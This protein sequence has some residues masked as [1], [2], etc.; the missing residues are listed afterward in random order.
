[1]V[2]VA[3]LRVPPLVTDLALTAGTVILLII[4]IKVANDQGTGPPGPATYLTAAAIALPLPL[5][6][7]WPLGVLLACSALLF[8][9]YTQF[10]HGGLAPAVPLAVALYT[11]AEHGY[12]RWAMAVTAFYM[13]SGL[14]ILVVRQ[15]HDAL[16]TVANFT[17]EASLLVAISLLGEAVRARRGWSAEIRNRLR[18]ADA[19][20]ERE[21]ARRVAQ[22]RVRIA[23]DLHDVLAHTISALSIQARVVLDGLPAEPSPVR[24]AATAMLSVSREAM[25]EVRAT[26][27]LLRAADQDTAPALNPTP[28]IADLTG[29]LATARATG[30]TARCETAGEPVAL[31][32]AVDVTA[33][34]IVQESLTNVIRHAGA[35]TVTVT[36]RY[37][38]SALE[39]EVAD[40][41]RGGPVS[42]PPAGGY[43]LVGIAERAAAVGGTATAGPGPV[44]GFLVTARLPLPAPPGDA[45]T[46]ERGPGDGTA[47]LERGRGSV[48][49]G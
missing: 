14:L 39:L 35:H 21:S 49:R 43:G 33:Y 3:R 1:M 42:W 34:R 32:A 26:V 2:S 30:L 12:L 28:G 22:E 38:P 16:T 45:V 40:D 9:F 8:V 10:S 31:P 11:A 41:G 7:R 15:H 18:A 17:Q 6:R 36:V 44:R 5:R 20:R 19:D 37:L 48:A 13:V 25:A 23:R 4:N 47:G 29:L 27:G 24:D 46:G